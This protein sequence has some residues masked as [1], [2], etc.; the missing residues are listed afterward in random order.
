MDAADGRSP[1]DLKH[2]MG[3]ICHH[4]KTDEAFG[5]VWRRN[6]ECLKA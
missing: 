5:G 2:S 1:R 4:L 6:G 3:E